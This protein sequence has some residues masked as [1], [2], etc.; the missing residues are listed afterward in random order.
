MT[1][2]D[3]TSVTTFPG[4]G[5]GAG[6]GVDHPI[7]NRRVRDKE[8]DEGCGENSLA[9]RVCFPAWDVITRRNIRPVDVVAKYP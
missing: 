6:A 5:R 9:V 8:D 2:P 3:D 1:L 7:P 4:S